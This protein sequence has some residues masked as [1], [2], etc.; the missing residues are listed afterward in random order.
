MDTDPSKG[1]ISNHVTRDTK[2]P[3]R[4]LTGPYLLLIG[5]VEHRPSI[6][7]IMS[8]AANRK[9]TRIEDMAYCL[10]GIFDIN[11]PLLYGEG[12]RAFIRLQLE[13]IQRTTGHPFLAWQLPYVFKRMGTTDWTTL[14]PALALGPHFFNGAEDPGYKL[15]IPN[16]VPIRLSV[17]NLGLSLRLRV[18][19][20]LE[21]KLKFAV[22][23]P[24]S[25][26]GRAVWMPLWKDGYRY[27]RIGFISFTLMVPFLPEVELNTDDLVLSIHDRPGFDSVRDLNLVHLRRPS[28][29]NVLLTF[30]GG[31]RH[32]RVFNRVSVSGAP[33][34]FPL[35]MNR[36]VLRIP[37]DNL[38]L[39]LIITEDEPALAYGAI[40]FELTLVNPSGGSRVPGNKAQ[41]VGILFVLR[42]DQTGKP[43]NWTCRDISHVTMG[44]TQSNLHFLEG[45]TEVGLR[46]AKDLAVSEWKQTC[47]LTAS[48]GQ[49]G[50]VQMDDLQRDLST[51]EFGGY[52]Q[53]TMTA[54][55]ND[56]DSGVDQGYYPVLA[57][58]MLPKQV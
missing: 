2:I 27:F 33:E 45:R 19:E 10:L 12:S 57:Q 40:E 48:R 24:L 49:L 31:L 47:V 37:W 17:S 8:W 34:Y 21:P 36:P 46:A 1:G 5:Q 54:T 35:P 55:A 44:I 18:V 20:T 6:A 30:P 51:P 50:L 56:I 53:K 22:V 11:M 43:I 52:G 41:R 29:L 14:L 9:T 38:L 26:T 4:L 42:L 58:I 15:Q 28:I 32:Y 25:Q 3:E 13:I 39:R 16:S 7:E 23:I